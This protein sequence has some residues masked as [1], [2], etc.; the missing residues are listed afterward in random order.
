DDIKGLAG[1]D[2]DPPALPDRE[3]ADAV[4][5]AEGAAIEMH[6]LAGP[7]RLG[8]QP[9]DDVGI[10]ALR[11]EADVLAVLLRSHAQPHGG[12]ALAH[13]LLRHA[14]ERKAQEVDLLLRRREQEIAL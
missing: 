6:D 7:G 5:A 14:A 10:A 9:R 2:A 12:G 11:H 13:L 3:P 4:M 1:G 8:P